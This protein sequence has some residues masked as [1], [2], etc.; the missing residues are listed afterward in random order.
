LSEDKKKSLKESKLMAQLPSI[1]VVQY[2]GTWT[3]YGSIQYIQMELCFNTLRRALE[4]NKNFFNRNAGEVINYIEF[5]L[6][7]ELLKEITECL[8]FLHKYD[9]PIIHRDLKPDNILI[10]NGSNERFVK[11]GDF[12][13][14]KFQKSDGQT[15][16]ASLGTVKYTAPDVLRGR[17]YDTSADIYSL[18]VIT[19]ELFDI[20]I[21]S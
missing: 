3:E 7:Y 15:N 5:Y 16:T 14:A 21:D 17:N 13:L 1:Y 20:D 19:Q 12:G 18:G 9:P 4:Q 6:S 2:Y 11:I 8:N 10:T